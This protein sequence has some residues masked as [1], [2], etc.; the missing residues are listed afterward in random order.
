MDFPLEG[1]TSKLDYIAT[2]GTAIPLSVDA[3]R[4]KSSGEGRFYLHHS[5]E[6]GV[7]SLPSVTTSECAVGHVINGAS[8][9][10]YTLHWF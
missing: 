1:N 7:V 9:D 4:H 6:G 10:Y 8:H 2:A 3:E 5:D